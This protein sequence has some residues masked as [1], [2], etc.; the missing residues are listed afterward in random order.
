MLSLLPFLL[1][2]HRGEPLGPPL[3][4]DREAHRD[5]GGAKSI[6]AI[7]FTSTGMPRWAAPKM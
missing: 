2:S 7:T 3:L 6:V 1:R 5:Q 4:H